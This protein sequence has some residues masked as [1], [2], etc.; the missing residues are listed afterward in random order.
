MK[1]VTPFQLEFDEHMTAASATREY[2][3]EPFAALVELAA[4]SLRR[5]GKLLLFGNGGS[6]AQAQHLATELTVRLVRDRPPLSAI[7]LVA[8][9]VALTAIG[10]DYGFEQLFARQI[11]AIGRPGDLAIGMSTTGRS[12]NV[13]LGLR[14]AKAMGLSAA[15]FSGGDGGMLQEGVAYPLL[16]VPSRSTARIQEMHALLGHAFCAALECALGLIDGV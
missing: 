11:L 8:D 6:A 5:G 10:N 13:V 9:G 1:V 3:A 12:T 7:A 14:A 4:A 2:V 15:A 16:C